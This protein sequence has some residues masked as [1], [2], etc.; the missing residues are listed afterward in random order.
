MLSTVRYVTAKMLSDSL[1]LERNKL[2]RKREKKIQFHSF[3]DKI[4]ASKQ[5]AHGNYS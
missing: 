4:Q 1:Y 5:Q 2:V 3:D